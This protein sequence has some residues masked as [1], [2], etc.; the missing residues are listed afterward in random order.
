MRTRRWARQKA[1]A[2]A[3]LTICKATEEVR[4]GGGGGGAEHSYLIDVKERNVIAIE[5]MKFDTFKDCKVASS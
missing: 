5:E 2:T 4:V 3:N 1:A